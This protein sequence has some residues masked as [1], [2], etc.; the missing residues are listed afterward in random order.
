MARQVEVK[1]RSFAV[2]CY[3]A[4]RMRLDTPFSAADTQSQQATLLCCCVLTSTDMQFT[5]DGECPYEFE[6][7]EQSMC[8]PG[9]VHLGILDT[10]LSMTTAAA[11]AVAE[12]ET[13][14]ISSMIGE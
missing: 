13:L 7:A 9:F 1:E 3:N 10:M 11:A 4:F 12:S 5:L 14:N 8:Q 2:V 6:P